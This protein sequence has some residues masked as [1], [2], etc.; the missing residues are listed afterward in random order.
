VSFK[1]EEGVTTATDVDFINQLRTLDVGSTHYD[2]RPLFKVG[3]EFQLEM[4]SYKLPRNHPVR[5]PTSIRVSVL[6]MSLRGLK[7]NLPYVI[8]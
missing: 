6:R 1:L 5:Q 4:G 7:S 3:S 2:T 8:L